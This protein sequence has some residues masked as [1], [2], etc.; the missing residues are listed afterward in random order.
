MKNFSIQMERKQ[1]FNKILSLLIMI[2]TCENEYTCTISCDQNTRNYVENFPYHFSGLIIFICNMPDTQESFYEVVERKLNLI[3]FCIDEYGDT[4]NIAPSLLM[5]RK[6]DLPETDAKI[7]FVERHGFGLSGER[8]QYKFNFDLLYVKDKSFIEFIQNE[9]IKLKNIQEEKEEQK[10]EEEEELEE[11]ENSTEKKEPEKSFPD[12]CKELYHN[13]SVKL[14][15]HFELTDFFSFNYC[16][17]S[18]DFFSYSDQLK[19]QDVTSDLHYIFSDETSDSDGD[20]NKVI[21]KY[22]I[23]FANVRV[24]Q[25]S[26]PIKALSVKFVNKIVNYN[27]KFM[28]IVNMKYNN[29]GFELVVPKRDG[30][31]IW[32]RNNDPPGL[33]ELFDIFVESYS[34]YF[35][36]TEANIEYFSLNNFLLFDKPTKIW[37]TNNVRK[38]TNFLFCNYDNELLNV[39]D[40]LPIPSHFMFYYSDEPK[41]L[42][43]LLKTF[44]IDSKQHDIVT[45]EEDELTIFKYNKQTQ[46]YTFVDNYYIKDFCWEDKYEIISK[47]K[48]ILLD[49]MDTNL[50][51]NCISLQVIPISNKKIKLLDIQQNIHYIDNNDIPDKFADYEILA[52]NCKKYY[53]ENINP[54]AIIRKLMNHIFIGGI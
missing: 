2:D 25:L 24:G 7:L 54:N 28:C 40:E 35:K 14:I 33:Y 21:P 26:P 38:Y 39:V 50:I 22:P 36:K 15:E 13:I 52:D 51:A 23:Y 43:K 5:L 45:I 3:E 11:Q 12:K 37:I 53:L 47:S 48:F 42:E 6:F 32:N 18:E 27:V 1:H 4:I 10:Q 41:K 19:F 31:I 44:T 16:I 29:K 34:D 9:F 20:T 46:D 30:I 8:D 17:S 49:S